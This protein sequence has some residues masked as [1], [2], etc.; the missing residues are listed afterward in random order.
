MR[1]PLNIMFALMMISSMLM[2]TATAFSEAEEPLDSMEITTEHRL[3]TPMDLPKLSPP[4]PLSRPLSA[5]QVLWDNGPLVNS[6]G[7]GFGGADESVLQTSLGMST[8]G[9]GHQQSAG[10]RIADDFTIPTGQFWEIENILFYAYQTGSTTT[11]TMTGVNYRIWD[12]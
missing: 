12:G 4:P 10:N 8:Y 7:T 3:D 11:S 5:T 9:Y 6:P 2:M 1:K